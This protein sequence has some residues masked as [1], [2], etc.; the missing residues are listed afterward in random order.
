M[1][2]GKEFLAD[3]MRWNKRWVEGETQASIAKD[4]DLSPAYV[5]GAIKV[6]D[7]PA[8]CLTMIR[9]DEVQIEAAIKFAKIPAKLHE[10]SWDL[11]TQFR[12]MSDTLLEFQRDPG[13]KATN[14][15]H[16]PTGKIRIEE[17][18]M[19]VKFLR[20]RGVE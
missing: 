6:L 20:D 17:V 10:A 3:V 4:L 1:T 18:N 19:V 16:S 2:R 9:K 11:A 7:L 13:E 8:R 15:R 14:I 5:S 12:A